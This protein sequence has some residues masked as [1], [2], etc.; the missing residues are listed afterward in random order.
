MGTL[1]GTWQ[2]ASLGA[3]AGLGRRQGVGPR[4]AGNARKRNLEANI[5][6]RPQRADPDAPDVTPMPVALSAEK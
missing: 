4:A 2:T 6:A 5:G 3:A 1:M